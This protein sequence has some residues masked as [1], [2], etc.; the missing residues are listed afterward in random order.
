[1]RFKRVGSLILCTLLAQASYAMSPIK[2]TGDIVDGSYPGQGAVYIQG[3]RDQLNSS[4]YSW[5]FVVSET[6]V[7]ITARS[8]KNFPNL[9]PSSTGPLSVNCNIGA[10]SNLYALAARVIPTLQ[11]GSFIKVTSVDGTCTELSVQR[12]TFDLP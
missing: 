5:D 12:T 2:I 9:N 10:S 6:S 4:L 3:T 7:L 1:M 8:P 11:K